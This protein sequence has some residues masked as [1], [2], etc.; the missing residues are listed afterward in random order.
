MAKLILITPEELQQL[1]LDS[2]EVAFHKQ[3]ATSALST[4]A[5]SKSKYLT[6]DE[7]AAYV[8]LSKS[9]IYGLTSARTIPF[10][11]RG[12]GLLFIKSELDEWML[13]GKKKS[14]SQMRDSTKGGK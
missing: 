12:K 7:A 3:N 10:I 5:I 1:L 14:R 13:Q 9:T 11:K 2:F 6:I 8:H 4:E